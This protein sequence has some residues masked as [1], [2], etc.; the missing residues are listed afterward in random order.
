MMMLRTEK[1][2][3]K[4]CG[5]VFTD[6][7]SSRRKYCSMPCFRK[8][9]TGIKASLETRKKMSKSR[10][11]RVSGMRGKKHTE[12]TKKKMSV[13]RRGRPCLWAEKI[14]EANKGRVFTEEHLKNISGENSS[15][16]M[17]GISFE[18]YDPGFNN[19]LKR[20]VRKRDDS[21]CQECG[22]S[23][24]KLGYALSVHHIDYNKR[25]NILDNLICLCRNCHS[26]TN[27]S[28]KDWT[29]YFSNMLS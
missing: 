21:T 11:G 17:G 3:C 15:N 16:W 23:E 28:R 27:Y 6:Y 26:Q 13:I 29:R 8:A 12:K 5:K 7:V 18:P 1:V 2:K 4:N 9:R 20:K 24:E 14:S 19:A 10:T 22:Y 25:N